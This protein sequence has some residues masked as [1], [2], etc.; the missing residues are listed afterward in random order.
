MPECPFCKEIYSGMPDKCP[1]CGEDLT[2]ANAEKPQPVRAVKSKVVAALLA[3]FL[4]ETGAH[5][6]YLGYKKRGAIQATGLAA[7]IIGYACSA[8]AVLNDSMAAF[9]V[10]VVFLLYGAAV[11]IWAFVDFIRIVAGYLEPADGTIYT[12]DWSAYVRAT[13]ATAAAVTPKD[14]ARRLETLARLRQQGI[15]TEEEFELKKAELLK[16]L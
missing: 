9:V 1:H 8:A 14:S 16:K 5:S 12:E 13:Q 4:G 11:C 15:L 3:F 10:S 6:F 7:L 2:A